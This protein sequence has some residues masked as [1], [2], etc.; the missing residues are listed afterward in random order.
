MNSTT[1]ITT[2]T[3]KDRDGNVIC[4]K[5][6][7]IEDDFS[8]FYNESEFSAITKDQLFYFLLEHNT[9][10][11]KDGEKAREY[12][13]TLMKMDKT[14]LIYRAMRTKVSFDGVEEPVTAFDERDLV[15][16]IR[17]NY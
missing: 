16:H 13:K 12:F 7:T 11:L 1:K 14:E 5:K 8:G 10:E 15:N 6:T 3:I 9:T 17:K 4:V 2:K